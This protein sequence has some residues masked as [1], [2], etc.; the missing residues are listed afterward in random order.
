MD[1]YDDWIYIMK[2]TNKNILK[3][4]NNGKRNTIQNKKY[5]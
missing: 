1:Y 3:G 4:I 5:L 2:M